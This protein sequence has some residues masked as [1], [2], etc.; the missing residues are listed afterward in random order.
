MTPAPIVCDDGSRSRFSSAEGVV[1]EEQTQQLAYVVQE[2]HWR[3]ND[4]WN[5]ETDEGD[6]PMGWPTR[7]FTSREAAEAHRREKEL[8]DRAVENPFN[9]GGRWCDLS[10]KYDTKSLLALV[11]EMGL[12]EPRVYAEG[13]DASLDEWRDWWPGRDGGLTAEQADRLWDALDR[14]AFYEVVEVALEGGRP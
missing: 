10:T 4:S 14:V 2:I 11:R 13:W 9:F 3:Y 6:G 7:A 5:Y 1:S 12:P 8:A